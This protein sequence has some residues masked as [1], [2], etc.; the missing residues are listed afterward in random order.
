MQ[1]DTVLG[2]KSNG[3]MCE[4]KVVESLER[5]SDCLADILLWS[6]PSELRCGQYL[7]TVDIFAVTRCERVQLYK[8][9]EA[10]AE[11]SIYALLAILPLNMC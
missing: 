3:W 6:T 1:P 11:K 7:M 8:L 4:K 5:P 2:L 9:K 10:V